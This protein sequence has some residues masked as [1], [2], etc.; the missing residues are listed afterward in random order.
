MDKQ[1][2]KAALIQELDEIMFLVAQ[3]CVYDYPEANAYDVAMAIGESLAVALTKKTNPI[4][5]IVAA[6]EM[7]SWPGTQQRKDEFIGRCVREMAEIYRNIVD[8]KPSS[9]G[10]IPVPEAE[11]LRARFRPADGDSATYWQNSHV[12]DTISGARLCVDLIDS[13]REREEPSLAQI[14]FKAEVMEESEYPDLVAAYI[15]R[16]QRDNMSSEI[17]SA[18]L[19]KMLGQ[20]IISEKD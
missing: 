5:L 10:Y 14:R 13:A 20:I 9:T 1:D 8:R 6:I 18:M 7:E 19:R 12:F 4:T 16:M 3:C 11:T 15:R 17:I 2:A